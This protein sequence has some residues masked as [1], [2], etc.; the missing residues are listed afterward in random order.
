M[1]EALQQ[2]D[3]FHASAPLWTPGPIVADAGSSAEPK[4]RDGRV[5]RSWTPQSSDA[6]PGQLTGSIATAL[7]KEGFAVNA[8][9]CRDGISVAYGSGQFESEHGAVGVGAAV[10]VT[11]EE[12]QLVMQPGGWDSPASNPNLTTVPAEMASTPFDLC[13]DVL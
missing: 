5:S 11:D 12:V 10:Y 13:E 4:P 3:A 1:V 6:Q 9:S 2:L 8:V 7:A